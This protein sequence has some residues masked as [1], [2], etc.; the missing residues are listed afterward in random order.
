MRT[1]ILLA[2]S[3]S[4]LCASAFLDSIFVEAR[5]KTDDV[6]TEGDAAD[7]SAIYINKKSPGKSLI[8][9]T[10][11]NSGLSV[12]DIKGNRLQEFP[13][14]EQNNVDI[15]YNFPL[16]NEKIPLIATGNRTT[17]T[18]DFYKVNQENNSVERVSVK[19]HPAG[20]EIYGSCFYKSPKTKKYYYFVNSKAGEV[21]Q[22]EV[23]GGTDANIILTEVRRF[24]V[25]SQ[26]EG[27]VADDNYEAF[28]IGEEK[29]GIWRYQAEPNSGEERYLIDG[30]DPE[31]GH[32]VADVE[33]LALYRIGKKHGYL[34][35]S[36]QGE[37]AFTIYRRD[38]GNYVGKFAVTYQGIPVENCDGIEIASNYLGFGYQTGMVVVQDGNKTHSR[39]SFKMV[40]WHSLAIKFF[41]PLAQGFNDPITQP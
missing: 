30:T 20:L 38:N 40:P 16:G 4:A 2:L 39:Q 11:K 34:V 22:W 17:N 1:K 5:D 21:V 12:F 18:I 29:V 37:N 10:D 14:G 6:R 41:P 35:A 31:T 9:G 19:E 24:L 8:L 27:C 7:D 26:V 28:Y 15:R 3:F 32:L 25:G 23:Q 36:S 33:G 13:D